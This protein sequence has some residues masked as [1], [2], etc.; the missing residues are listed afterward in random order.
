MSLLQ[1]LRTTVVL[2]A[3]LT[4]LCAARASVDVEAALGGNLTDNSTTRHLE[5]EATDYYTAMLNAVNKERTAHGLP[6]LCKNRKLQEAAQAHS[7]DMA[8]R[9]FLSHTGSDGSTMASRVRAAGYRWTSLAENVAAGQSTVSSVM[10]SWM[11]SSGHRANILSAKNKMF[12]C[13]YSYSSS[14]KYKYY[15]TQDFASGSVIVPPFA[16]DTIDEYR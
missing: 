16:S 10:A 3:I 11:Q 2:A 5:M 1:I 13:S 14:S 12:G 9:S 4:T 7:A 8:R 15:W 6:K